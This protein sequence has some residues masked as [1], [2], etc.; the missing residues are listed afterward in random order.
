MKKTLKV[1]FY[2]Y[3]NILKKGFTN[4]EHFNEKQDYKLRAMALNWQ[5]VSVEKIN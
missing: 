4:I 5:I 2:S 1:T 3:S